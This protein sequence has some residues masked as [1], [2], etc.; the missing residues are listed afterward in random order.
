MDPL[1]IEVFFFQ[2]MTS[3]INVRSILLIRRYYIVISAIMLVQ[4][5]HLKYKKV[6][7]L[8]D[9]CRH[10]SGFIGTTRYNAT[11]PQTSE[12][13]RTLVCCKTFIFSCHHQMATVVNIN[14]L[15]QAHP[16]VYNFIFTCF[17][18]CPGRLQSNKQFSQNAVPRFFVQISITFLMV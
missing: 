14:M 11:Q 13:Q 15:A 7:V 18:P 1:K 17:S 8:T 3:E 2:S 6:N 12:L 10:L 5:P 9:W 4:H 16:F